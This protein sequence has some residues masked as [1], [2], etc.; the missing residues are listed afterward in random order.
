MEHTSDVIIGHMNRDPTQT[1]VFCSMPHDDKS[2][3]FKE[4][5]SA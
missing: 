3:G 1:N 2:Q 5:Q 4:Y